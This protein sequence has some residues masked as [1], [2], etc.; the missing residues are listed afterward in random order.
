MHEASSDGV[1]AYRMYIRRL[2]SAKLA[3]VRAN[4]ITYIRSLGALPSQLDGFGW[5]RNSIRNRQ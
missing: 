3:S 5:L 1:I 2:D 4:K